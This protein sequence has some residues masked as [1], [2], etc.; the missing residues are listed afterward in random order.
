VLRA[1]AQETGATPNQVI[2]AWMLRGDPPILPIIAGSR[3]EQVKENLGALDVALSDEQVER[4]TTAGNPDV[5][6]AWLR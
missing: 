1:V 4:L 3:P 5:K 6:K 2:I